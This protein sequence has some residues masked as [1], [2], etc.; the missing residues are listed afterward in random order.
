MAFL[1]TLIQN[2]DT[3]FMEGVVWKGE[4]IG[5]WR[6]EQG[7]YREGLPVWEEKGVC[8]EQAVG[9]EDDWSGGRAQR[10]LA[11]GCVTSGHQRTS[12]EIIVG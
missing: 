6:K 10:V 4:E 3:T 5:D 8:K 7:V 12:Q 1:R 11:V 2:L 9:S